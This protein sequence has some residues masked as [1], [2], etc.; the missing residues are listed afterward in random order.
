[1]LAPRVFSLLIASVLLLTTPLK[2]NEYLFMGTGNV[3]G[4]YYPIGNALCRLMEVN[5]TQRKISCTA[6]SSG[7]SID[8]VSN[9]LKGEVDL[10]IVQSDIHWQAYWGRNSFAQQERF[11]KMRSLMSLHSEAITLL[12][13][14]DLELSTLLDLKGKNVNIGPSG[15]GQHT[16]MRLIM[17]SLGWL[18]PPQVA[19]SELKPDEQ[20]RALCTR[21]V[22]AVAYVVGH[23]N[24][25]IDQATTMCDSTLLSFPESVIDSL[26]Q[27]YSYFRPITIT[28][29]IYQGNPTSVSTLGVSATLVVTSDMS[30]QTAYNFVAAVME[31]LDYLRSLHPALAQLSETEMVKVGLSAPLHPGALRY[32]REHG[33][34]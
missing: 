29:G 11:S 13:H 33:W 23:P 28:P 5:Q 25:S 27:E 21:K 18:E 17:D 22:D 34:R 8:N 9:L 19:L 26:T 1:M 24:V 4:V 31:N 10:A 30:E 12:A 15:S 16:T 3:S 32:Y 6:E 2:A 14:Q 7:G 20:S